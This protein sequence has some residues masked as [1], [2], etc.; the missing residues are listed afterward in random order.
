MMPQSQGDPVEKKNRQGDHCGFGNPD[1]G[2]S[3]KKAKSKNVSL[4]DRL[5]QIWCQLKY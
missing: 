2:Q 5:K 1:N 3:G 4:Y